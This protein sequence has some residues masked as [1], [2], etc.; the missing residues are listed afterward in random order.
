MKIDVVSKMLIGFLA[1]TGMCLLQMFCSDN[2]SVLRMWAFFVVA[3]SWMV[4]AVVVSN[5]RVSK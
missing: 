5:L 4:G 1:F 3:N 2:D